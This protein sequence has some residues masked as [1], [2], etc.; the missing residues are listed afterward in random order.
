MAED[1]LRIT[2]SAFTR[3]SVIVEFSDGSS[4]AYTLEQLLSLQA[5][6]TVIE[7]DIIPESP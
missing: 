3:G 6:Q 7:E 5:V 1:D 4:R 2:G